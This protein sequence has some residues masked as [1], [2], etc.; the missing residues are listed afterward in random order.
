LLLDNAPCHPK[1]DALNTTSI[2]QPLDQ[3]IVSAVKTIFRSKVLNELVILMEKNPNWTIQDW[4]KNWNLWK[5]LNIL[6]QSW[7]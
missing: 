6:A 4:V 3:G 7:E 1:I 5:A 2:A